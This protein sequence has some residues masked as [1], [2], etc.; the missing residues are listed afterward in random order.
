MSNVWEMKISK[1][2]QLM[3][4]PSSP[5]AIN[6]LS[7]CRPGN[8]QRQWMN[9]TRSLLYKSLPLLLLFLSWMISS[10]THFTIPDPQWNLS[11]ITLVLWSQFQIFASWKYV[12]KRCLT[13][14]HDLFEWKSINNQQHPFPSASSPTSCV[15]T[16]N[17]SPG[18]SRDAQSGSTH[19][20]LTDAILPAQANMNQH[21]S[22]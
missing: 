10:S 14:I 19:H 1:I 11:V 4:G 17:R 9:K 20:V 8:N 7:E 21:Q 15:N 12:S 5:Q 13:T 22:Q 2:P 18:R 6:F 3:D 16:L